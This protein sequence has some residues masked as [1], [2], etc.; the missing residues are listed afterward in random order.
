M[1]TIIMI[2]ILAIGTSAIDRAI[3]KLE[4]KYDK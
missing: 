3:D 1:N 4:L 2:A